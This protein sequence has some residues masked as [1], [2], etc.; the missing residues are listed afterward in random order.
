MGNG[1]SMTLISRSEYL[2]TPD[3]GKILDDGFNPEFKKLQ[4][5]RIHGYISETQPKDLDSMAEGL[6]SFMNRGILFLCLKNPKVGLR[7]SFSGWSDRLAAGA[8]GV[9]GAMVKSLVESLIE[10]HGMEEKVAKACENPNSFIIPYP[11]IIEMDNAKVGG[12]WGKMK[13]I[14]VKVVVQNAPDAK[15][16][17]WLEAK[18]N[19]EGWP[20]VLATMKFYDEALHIHDDFISKVADAPAFIA[21]WMSKNNEPD[22]DKMSETKRSLMI[23]EC[24]DYVA[25]TLSDSGYTT[26]RIKA[27]LIDELNRYKDCVPSGILEQIVTALE[28]KW[29]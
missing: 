3:A 18:N 9:P 19:D 21:D 10:S 22:F 25:R 11:D 15:T 13:D 16:T 5:L 4:G 6:F 7:H 24:Q 26:E 20:S 29:I 12:I 27:H 2:R 17:Y 28:S 8:G 23:K 14:I 1:A